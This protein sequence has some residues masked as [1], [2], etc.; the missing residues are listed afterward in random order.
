[1][2][3]CENN[4]DCVQ[5]KVFGK[6]SSEKC[7]KCD[8]QYTIVDSVDDS[9]ENYYKKC[10]FV[11]PHDNCTFFFSYSKLNDKVIKVQKSKGKITYLNQNQNLIY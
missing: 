7:N 4:K 1:M 3:P 6:T 10:Q 2:G 11:D 8:I 9:N 5:C